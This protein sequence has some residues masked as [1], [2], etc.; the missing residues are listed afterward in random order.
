MAALVAGTR[1]GLIHWS[2][3]GS[4]ETDSSTL[5]FVGVLNDIDISV[6][7][8]GDNPATPDAISIML[9]VPSVC[10]FSSD[11]AKLD[12]QYD[13]TIQNGYRQLA[14]AIRADSFHE[15]AME[16]TPDARSLAARLTEIVA[17]VTEK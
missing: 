9:A 10:R 1:A 13:V 5:A 6:N 14:T 4:L 12:G 16:R 2:V 17:E 3:D 15:L 11:P 7:V 8:A